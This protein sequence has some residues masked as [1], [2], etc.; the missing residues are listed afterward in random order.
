MAKKSSEILFS[1]S[2]IGDSALFTDLFSSASLDL[3]F[4]ERFSASTA[5]GN[6]RLNGFQFAGR[7]KN[8]L[9]RVSEKCLTGAHRFTPYLEKLKP[10]GRSKL[11][12]LVSIPT[13]RDRVV[14]AQLSRFLA[15]LFPN[16]VPKNVAGAYVRLVAEDLTCL[17]EAT[18]YICCTDIKTFYDSIK[19]S[20]LMDVLSR[21]IKCVAALQL[22]EHAIQTPTIP[23]NTRR[24]SFGNFKTM[25]GIPQGLAISNI[26]AAIY[27]Q[28]VDEAMKK[29]GVKYLRYVDDVLMYGPYDLVVEAHK[30]LAGRLKWRGL[31]L[32]ALDSGKSQIKPVGHPFSYL[33]YQFEKDKVTVREATVE[34]FLQSI[35]AKFSDF[36]HNKE[37]RLQ[38]F[39]YLNTE[40]LKEIFLLE[41]NERITGAVSD[42]KRYGWIAYFSQITDLT[43]LHRLDHAIESL[44]S[45][46]ADF[47]GRPPVG[48]R[49]VKRA[50]WE[51]RFDPNGGYVRDYDKI[52]TLTEKLAFLVQRGRAD[53]MEALTDQQIEDRFSKY[54]HHVLAAMHA[55]E[56]GIYG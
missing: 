14:L 30:S 50:Y 38:K 52:S 39:K 44:F 55:D 37:R 3:V 13:I 40:R 17:D 4:R 46:L 32:H 10:K 33:G 20:R 31:S 27:M 36:S 47:E 29:F 48:L 41:L 21:K 18:D 11:P 12:R 25:R 8:E 45:R 26:L 1:L 7:A 23:Q 42:K 54:V 19:R 43:L 49:K 2:M 35:S 5:K 53:P 34:R 24:S 6:D 56:A 51:M 22:I 16:Q 15:N 28:D 9:S